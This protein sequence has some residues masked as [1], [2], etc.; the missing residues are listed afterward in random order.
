MGHEAFARRT[1]GRVVEFVL[2]VGQLR[3]QIVASRN[4]DIE[5]TLGAEITFH[6]LSDSKKIAFGR[7]QLRL[8]RLDPVLERRG[9]D[10]E[11]HITL[12]Q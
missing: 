2:G 4:G 11:Q 8:E 10:P 1:D 7:H 6:Q 12:L 5:F 9:V 3:L